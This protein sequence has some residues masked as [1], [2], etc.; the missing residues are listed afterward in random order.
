[1]LLLKRSSHSWEDPAADHL[2][3]RHVES[4]PES[5]SIERVEVGMI[6]NPDTAKRVSDALQEMFAK[7]C[8]SCELV[9]A[10]CSP[11]EHSAYLKATSRVAN[12]IVFDVMEPLYVRH[13]DLKPANWDDDSPTSLC[14]IGS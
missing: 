12:G 9:R 2:I 7:L 4:N 3:N 14:S 8:E 10:T 13:P 11:E 5:V 1:M 6:S